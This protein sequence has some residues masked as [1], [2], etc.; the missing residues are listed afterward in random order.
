MERYNEVSTLPDLPR[1]IGLPPARGIFLEGPYTMEK[2]PAGGA[3]AALEH[4]FQIQRIDDTHVNVRYGTVQDVDPVNIGTD[5]AVATGSYTVYIDVEVNTAGDTIVAVTLRVLTGALPADTD[6]HA[7]IKIGKVTV[8]D[9]AIESIS[10][11]ATHSLRFT[12]CDRVQEDT[13]A[14]PPVDFERGTYEF[15]GF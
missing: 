11:A 4:P 12:V 2:P 8:V 10:Q 13:E 9:D 7:Y 3:G 1:R 6:H 5:I 15:W 14:E